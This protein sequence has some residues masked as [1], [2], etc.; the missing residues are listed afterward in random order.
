M[1]FGHCLG[2]LEIR[3][4]RS[5]QKMYASPIQKLID[6]FSRL[7][8]V[9]QRTAERFVFYLLK[10]GKKD[11]AELTLALKGLI[12]QVKSCQQCWDFSDASPCRI[13]AQP[14]RDQSTICVV[15]EPQDL[16]AIEKTGQ[17]TGLYHLLRGTIRPDNEDSLKYLKVRELIERV[18]IKDDGAKKSVNQDYLPADGHGPSSVSEV[19]LALNHDLNGE[20]TALFLEKRLSKAR[21]DLKITRLA[22]GLPMGSDMQYADEVTLGSALR[23]RH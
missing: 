13:C 20:H 3:S 18:R 6:A 12:E 4:I 8:T 9:G 16:Q 5:I 11:V 15:A 19:I 17:Y 7:P 22:R 1:D 14:N 21:P 23:H 2:Q 10:S